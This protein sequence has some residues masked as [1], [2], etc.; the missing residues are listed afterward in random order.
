M[1]SKLALGTILA[2]SLA[3]IVLATCVTPAFATTSYD[4]SNVAGSTV[5]NLADHQP[6]IQIDVHHNDR[7]D[8]GVG[9]GIDLSL[10]A[11]MGPLAGKW[12]YVA[13]MTD[14]LQGYEWA[15][16]LHKKGA[17][18]NN[19]MLVKPWE[20]QVCRIGKTAFAYWTKPLTASITGNSPVGT[21]WATILGASS[22]TLPPGCLLFQGYGDAETGTGGP[23][24][25][26]SGVT[27]SYSYTSFDAHA[28]FL[29]PSWHYC[30]T[31]GNPSTPSKIRTEATLTYTQMP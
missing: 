7:G 19:I 5:I 22:V 3:F 13:V 17:S 12:I 15:K 23:F 30:G 4:H 10:R 25:M 21:P 9:D 16:V 18:E 26:P 2:L 28:T 1:K 14:S 20:I 8:H 27:W 29:C 31:V 6:P 24:T 11:T